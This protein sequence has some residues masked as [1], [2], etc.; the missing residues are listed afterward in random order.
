MQTSIY[1]ARL[2]GP[3]GI[4]IGAGM[5]VN[6]RVYRRMAEEFLESYALIYFSGLIAGTAGLAVVLA[7]NVWSADW[8]VVVTLL[9][10]AAFVGG[11]VRIVLPQF[12]RTIGNAMFER[13]LVFKIGGAIT[14]ALGLGLGYEGYFA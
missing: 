10:W 7:H 4:A 1:L 5:L 3:I 9:G 8:R 13:P 2:M 11:I 6:S 12:T 14:L